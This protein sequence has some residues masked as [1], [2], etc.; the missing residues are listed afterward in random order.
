MLS[1]LVKLGKFTLIYLASLS[2]SYYCFQK[3]FLNLTLLQSTDLTYTFIF[4]FA[5]N[6]AFATYCLFSL[7]FKFGISLRIIHWFYSFMFLGVAPLAQA[8]L[9]VWRHPI[10]IEHFALTNFVILCANLT[11]FITST[12]SFQKRRKK[13]MIESNSTVRNFNFNQK[14][15][16]KNAIFYLSSICAFVAI[17][18][19]FIYGFHFQGRLFDGFLSINFLQ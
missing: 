13:I 17:S 9:N 19:T 1:V 5:F 18:L 16:N 12:I 2:I 6:L 14:M 15:I 8:Y 11:F 4:S 3:Y 10:N 7:I